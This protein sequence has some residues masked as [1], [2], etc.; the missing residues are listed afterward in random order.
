MNPMILGGRSR[1]SGPSYEIA[2]SAIFDSAD[3]SYLSRTVSDS[4]HQKGT[5]SF[6]FKRSILGTLQTLFTSYNPS[7]SPKYFSITLNTDNKLSV[8]WKT[9]DGTYPLWLTTS[10]VFRDTAEWYHCVI[11]VDTTQGTA[12]DRCK[13][14]VNGVQTVSFDTSIYCTQNS[15]MYFGYSSYPNHI[16]GRVNNITF[17]YL[18]AYLAEYRHIDGQALDPSYFGETDSNNRWV[19][20]AYAGSYGTNGFYLPFDDATHF[21]KDSSGNGNDFTDSGFTTDHQVVDTPT[22]NY[23][24]L[25]VLDVSYVGGSGATITDGA[26]TNTSA[27]VAFSHHSS[28]ATVPCPHSGK[29]YAEV[30]IVAQNSDTNSGL[31]LRDSS[32]N[33]AF[34]LQFRNSA[35]SGEISSTAGTPSSQTGLGAIGS[36]DIVSVAY[37]ADN[38]V[39]Q[40]YLN[41]IAYGSAITGI[42]TANDYSIALRP[43]TSVGSSQC[44]QKVDFGQR[45]FT[46]TPPTG[47]KALC[48]QNLPEPDIILSQ[49]YFDAVLDTGANIKATAEA[50]FGTN[51]LIWIKDRDNANNHQLIDHVRGSTA[52]LRSNTTAAETTYSAPA[53]NSVAWCFKEGVLPGFDI[54]LGTLD[55]NSSTTIINHSLGAIPDLVIAKRTSTTSGWNVWHKD[56]S[57]GT[58]SLQ[59]HTTAAE[60]NNAAIFASAPTSTQVTLGTAW[61]AVVSGIV[62]YLFASI[63]GFSNAF[64]YTGNGSADGPFINLGF[65]PALVMVKRTDSTGGWK[66]WDAARNPVNPVDGSLETQATAAESTSTIRCDLVS[67][68]FKLLDTATSTN[69]SGGTYIGI[70]FAEAPFKYSRAR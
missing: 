24:T 59:L 62:V 2:N 32:G 64:T 41:N 36:G 25:N 17:W 38:G 3:S 13:V 43:I 37:D 65:K 6:W 34:A 12:A 16:G 44:T 18:S 50:V 7:D 4:S 68:G 57:G 21:G 60:V 58:Y 31:W 1:A 69:A 8:L 61:D 11:S 53:G 52:V 29:W 49:N 35:G 20:K 9:A 40:L 42:P 45:G 70:A 33:N 48:S 51:D 39:C 63:P 55:G 46:Y 30:S 54:A 14:Y 67:N 19:P 22:N 28:F 47:Y 5:W 26:L 27:S 66:M 56:L 10:Q 15:L 23:P